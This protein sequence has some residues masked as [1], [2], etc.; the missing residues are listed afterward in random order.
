M[1]TVLK[2]VKAAVKIHCGTEECQVTCRLTHVYPDGAAPYY[3]VVVP[4]P[5]PAPRHG[6]DLRATQWLGIKVAA[7]RVMAEFG[8]TCTHHHAVG[9]LHRP[10]YEIE[11]GALMGET[12]KAIKRVHDPAGVMNP[13]VLVQTTQVPASSTSAL[14]GVELKLN[15]A[16]SP[17][18]L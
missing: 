1:F 7:V 9:K 3:T 8:A 11:R 6:A 15:E 12:L 4:S 2:A 18:K 10:H 5:I 17:A 14:G 16:R 13:D